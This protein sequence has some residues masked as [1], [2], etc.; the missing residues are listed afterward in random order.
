MGWAV[1]GCGVTLGYYAHYR[2]PMTDNG[3]K[4]WRRVDS[5][6]MPAGPSSLA[7]LSASRGVLVGDPG[8][9]LTE[10]GA[11]TQD[12]GKHWSTLS[13][14]K[15]DPVG[16]GAAL[17]ATQATWLAAHTVMVVNGY[18]LDRHH[19]IM[20][21]LEAITLSIPQ[22]TWHLMRLATN[23][24]GGT[25][26]ALSFATPAR[27]WMALAQRQGTV[28]VTTT[29]GRKRWIMATFGHHKRLRGGVRFLS[30]LNARQ[31]CAATAMQLWC[32]TRSSS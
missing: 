24:L 18:W 25:V 4:T 6:W 32:A 31:G 29:N 20:P 2:I 13:V 9:G 23:G 26:G 11:L 28:L 10:A 30:R 21:I 8:G 19:E 17:T 16:L 3:G 14:L 5:L 12:G 22:S 15:A 27:G 1:E 7:M